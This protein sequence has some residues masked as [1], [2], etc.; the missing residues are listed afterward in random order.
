MKFKLI[1]NLR[2]IEFII[3]EYR[4]KNKVVAYFKTVVKNYHKYE[5]KIKCDH[6]KLG[7]ITIK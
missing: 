4:E 5:I 6:R 7:L 2:S 3:V 1:I